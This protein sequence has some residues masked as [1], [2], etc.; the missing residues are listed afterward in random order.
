MILIE[1][2]TMQAWIKKNKQANAAAK[3]KNLFLEIIKRGDHMI[4]Q[5]FALNE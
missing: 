2:F 4:D 3:T 5:Q 1:Q